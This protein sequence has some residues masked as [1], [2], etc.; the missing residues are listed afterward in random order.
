[1]VTSC[2]SRTGSILVRWV[3]NTIFSKAR[4]SRRRLQCSV[5]E[6]PVSLLMSGDVEALLLH[7]ATFSARDKTVFVTHLEWITA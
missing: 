7:P 2:I 1:M 5:W 3:H 4:Y 6:G